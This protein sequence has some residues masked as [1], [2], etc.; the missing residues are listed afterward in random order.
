MSSAYS[1]TE[2][3][4]Q[5]SPDFASVNVKPKLEKGKKTYR[6]NRSNYSRLRRRI[7]IWTFVL[8]LLFKLWRNSKNGLMLMVIL[9]K[10][11]APVVVFKRHGLEKIYWS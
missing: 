6:W 2:K 8:I 10:K 1:N 4:L 11:E 7:D 3:Y 9:R 5:S